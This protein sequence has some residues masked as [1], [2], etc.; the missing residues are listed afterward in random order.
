[1]SVF[2]TLREKRLPFDLSTV[3]LAHGANHETDY[4]ARSLTRRVPTLMHEDFALSE[5]SAIT[6]YLDETF[7]E[8]PVYPRDR[9]LRARARQVQAWLRSDLL[10]IRQER[11]TEVVFYGSRGAPLSAAAEEA[12]QKLF[13]AAEALLPAGS[14]N[15]FG[16]WCIADT[17]L[18]L[19]LNRLV[20]N[21]DPVPQRLK[22][23]AGRQW[24]R[25]AVQQWVQL[26]RPPL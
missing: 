8:I 5:S 11:S 26:E 10:P 21:G 25:P 16:E 18:A 9:H 7:P 15:L 12:A 13:S 1:M 22:D 2:V 23:Y 24:Q 20:L 6:E 4:A 17:D 3:D 14:P 19:M